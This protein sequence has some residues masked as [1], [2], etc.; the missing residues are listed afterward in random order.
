[1]I[2]LFQHQVFN[3]L[4]LC[5]DNINSVN[6]RLTSPLT[7]QTAITNTG[8][9]YSI[10]S[11]TWSGRLSSSL[12]VI[13][14][15]NATWGTFFKSSLGRTGK[16][17]LINL[18]RWLS[19]FGG[20]L[21]WMVGDDSFGCMTLWIV[22]VICKLGFILLLSLVWRKFMLQ[23]LFNKIIILSSNSR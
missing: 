8:W 23:I 3:H 11:F 6:R 4:L 18:M 15:Y 22:S 7:E 19:F 10:V 14:R 5:K 13:V 17:P 1:M 9:N 21:R 12:E 20:A 16:S 2:P